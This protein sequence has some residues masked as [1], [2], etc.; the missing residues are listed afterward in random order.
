M[1]IYQNYINILYEFSKSNSEK[2]FA[3]NK[4]L[5]L[6]SDALNRANPLIIELGV[7][8]GQSTRVFLNA[9]DNKPDAKLISI[10]IEDCSSSVRSDRWEFVQQDF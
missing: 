2:K 3:A 8:K 10:D 4:L 9:I 6:H 5:K 1:K 7:D